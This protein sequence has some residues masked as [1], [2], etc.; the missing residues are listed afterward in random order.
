MD[1]T[2]T[3]ENFSKGLQI[4]SRIATTR[5]SLPILANILI[6]TQDGQLKLASTDLEMGVVTMIGAKVNTEGAI[7]LPAR[8]LVDFILNNTDPTLKIGVDQGEAKIHSERHS[9]TVKGMD[10]SEFPLIPIV[11]DAKTFSLPAKILRNSLKDVIFAAAI[12]DARPVLNGI[13]IH[14]KEKE[15]VLA[16]T[17]SYRLAE[18]HIPLKGTVPEGT[19]LL[20]VRAAQ[21]LTRILPDSDVMATIQ[22]NANQLLLEIENTQI[23]SRLIDGT[24][25]DYTQII[26]TLATTSLIVDRAEFISAVKMASLFARDASHNIQVTI[27]PPTGCTITAVSTAIGQNVATVAAKVTGE[28]LEIAFNAKYV[29]DALN[30]MASE[31]IRLDC[32]GVDRAGVFRAEGDDQ[33]LS[34]VMPLRT[35]G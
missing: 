1:I 34:L 32:S 15:M 21:E 6:Q 3:Q 33:Y 30:T 26:P 22:F 31:M 17:D 11:T 2:C 24:F 7:T 23:I 28:P 27:T 4:V 14:L 9:A 8:L 29:L 10:A 5:S 20:P 12:D 19:I 18:R 13:C 35:D 16:T 25:P